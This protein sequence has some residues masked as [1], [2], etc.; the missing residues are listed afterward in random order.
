LSQLDLEMAYATG[1]KVKRVVSHLMHHL[2]ETLHKKYRRALVDGTLSSGTWH[3]VPVEI[4]PPTSIPFPKMDEIDFFRSITY[5]NAMR[6]YG[7]DKPDLRMTA[8]EASLVSA[9]IGHVASQPLMS[10]R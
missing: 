10:D 4:A 6:Q 8:E 9:C 1:E 3:P 5:E 7:I 2:F